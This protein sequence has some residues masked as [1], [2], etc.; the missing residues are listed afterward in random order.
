ME[1]IFVFIG[2]EGDNFV[3]ISQ[4]GEADS[5]GENDLQNSYLNVNKTIK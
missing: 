4:E 1:L 3:F 2:H 5:I